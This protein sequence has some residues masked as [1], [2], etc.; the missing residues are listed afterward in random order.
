MFEAT[1]RTIAL[2]DRQESSLTIERRRFRENGYKKC[3]LLDSYSM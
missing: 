2:V 3:A 1:T